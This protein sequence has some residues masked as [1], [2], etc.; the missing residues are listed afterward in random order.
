MRGACE[1]ARGYTPMRV[2]KAILSGRGANVI[3][4]SRLLEESLHPRHPDVTLIFG[5]GELTGIVPAPAR[6]TVT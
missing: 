6:G 4:M 2:V 5:S 1:V 3:Y